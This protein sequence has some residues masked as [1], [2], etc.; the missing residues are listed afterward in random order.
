MNQFLEHMI[1][2]GSQTTTDLST[3][4]YLQYTYSRFLRLVVVE[5]SVVVPEPFS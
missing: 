4:T 1:P 3:T 5:R 2:C